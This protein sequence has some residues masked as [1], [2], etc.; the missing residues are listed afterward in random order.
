MYEDVPGQRVRE[1]PDL[2]AQ[3]DVLIICL[4]EERM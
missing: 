3:N 4:G 1:K 2:I